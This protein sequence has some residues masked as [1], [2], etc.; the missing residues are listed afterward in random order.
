MLSRITMFALVSAM[1]LFAAGCSSQGVQ[2]EQPA[3]PSP[4]SA[5][6]QQSESEAKEIELDATMELGG[7]VFAYPS[8]WSVSETDSGTVNV[9][10]DCGGNVSF[11]GGTDVGVELYGVDSASVEVAD[12]WVENWYS[13]AADGTVVSLTGSIETQYGESSFKAV[14]PMKMSADGVDVEGWSCVMGK[15]TVT[16]ASVIAM[17]PPDSPQEYKDA[18]KAIVDSAHMA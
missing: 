14:A 8:S 11:I 17:I 18:M 7:A 10:P 4:E 15:G 3:Q 9:A 12:T 5:V 16:N 1:A 13:S 6:E 2:G